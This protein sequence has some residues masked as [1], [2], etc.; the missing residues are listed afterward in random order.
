VIPRK[1]RLK[2][3][4]S[5][6]ECTVDL[7]GLH[8]AVLCGKNGDGKS[9]LLDGMTWALWGKARGRTEEDRIYLGAQDLLVEFEFEVGRV[10]FRVIR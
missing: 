9:A 8:M 3:F 5:Y 10:Q 6:R 1:L 2:N 4:L 7:S